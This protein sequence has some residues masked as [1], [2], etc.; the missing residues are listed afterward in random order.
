MTIR[1][2]HPLCPDC[3]GRGFVVTPKGKDACFHCAVA[4][5]TEW[6]SRRRFPP[7]DRQPSHW[8]EPVPD[9]A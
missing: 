8:P 1:P 3:D 7:D 4:A 6:I 9:A 2:L 5:E